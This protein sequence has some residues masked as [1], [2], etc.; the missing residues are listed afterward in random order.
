MSNYKLKDFSKWAKKAGLS[1]RDLLKALSEMNAGLLGDR[2]GSNIYKKRIGIKGRGKSGGVRTILL[3][4][5]GD[6]SL[7][8]Y[9]FKKNELDNISPNEEEQLRI[10]AKAFLKK[11]AAQ[12]VELTQSGTIIALK[13]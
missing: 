1:D 11:T 12:R 7:F 5:K 9:G 6:V 3:Y 13:E 8:L 4:K 10:F 2:L